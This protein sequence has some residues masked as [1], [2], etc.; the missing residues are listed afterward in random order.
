M[1]MNMWL[2]TDM[3]MIWEHVSLFY[4]YEKHAKSSFSVILTYT[5]TRPYSTIQKYVSVQFEQVRV[6]QF[7]R[8][9]CVLSYTTNVGTQ[10]A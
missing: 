3:T 8:W 1:L 6:I 4:V 7:L 9:P 2:L 10:L 5:K